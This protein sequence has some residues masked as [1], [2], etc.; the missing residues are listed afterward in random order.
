MP[1]RRGRKLPVNETAQGLRTTSVGSLPKPDYLLHARAQRARNEISQ[2]EL[3]ELSRRA[4]QEWIRF[5]EEIRVDIVVD[6]A[7]YRGGMA[8]YFAENLAGMHLSGRAR[9]SRT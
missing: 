6:G 9:S 4:T 8:A 7:M 5:Q 2:E 3:D 1:S